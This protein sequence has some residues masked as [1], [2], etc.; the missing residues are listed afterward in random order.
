[1]MPQESSCHNFSHFDLNSDDASTEKMMQVV[2]EQHDLLI[3][4]QYL[5]KNSLS[6]SWESL[7]E[8]SQTDM[9][10]ALDCKERKEPAWETVSSMTWMLL[11]MEESTAGDQ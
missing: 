6:Y 1:M 3:D 5:Q 10:R 9:L 7:Q 8:E 4:N 11:E 2:I